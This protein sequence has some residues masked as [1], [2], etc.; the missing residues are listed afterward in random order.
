MY[1]GRIVEQ[2]EAESL[3]ARPTHPYTRALVS[4]SRCRAP[5]RERI[6]LQGDPP[7]PVDVPSG[8]AFHP[9]CP[10]AVARSAA[11]R[12]RCCSRGR[13]PPGRLP[14][15]RRAGASRSPP[16]AAVRRLPAAARRAHHP[17]RH[18]LRLRGAAA[19]GRSGADHHVGRRAARGD[20]GLPRGLG[21]RAAD[22]GPVPVLYRPMPSP[23]TSAGRCAMAA[24]RSTWWWSACRRRSRS[25]CRRWR[26]RSASAS[27]PAS[28]PRCTATRSPTALTMAVSVAGFTVPSF[29]LALLLVLVFAVQLGWLPSG[30]RTRSSTRSCPSSPWASAVRPSWRASPARPCWRCWASPISA[31]PR[32]RACAW[33]R[34]VSRHALPNAA[35]PTVTIIGFMVG[36]LIAGA[37]VVESVFS[38]PGVGRLLVVAVANR[39]LAVVQCDPDGGRGLDGTGQPHRRPALWLARSARARHGGGH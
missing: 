24:P 36:S 11:P 30:G 10:F 16:D 1:L 32:P 26:S 29:V 39:D 23:A 19:V 14:S 27:R 15:R 25:P 7:N 21:P 20:K 31:P 37:V 22:L 5:R 38:W 34:V 6:L 28:T 17:V 9:R 33:R 4:R 12:R 3:F 35:I 18:D 8:C 13:R 2:G